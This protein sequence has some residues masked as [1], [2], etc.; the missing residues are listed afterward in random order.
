MSTFDPNLKRKLVSLKEV[1]D[2]LVFS[3]V[4]FVLFAFVGYVMAEV[5]PT[6][7][8]EYINDFAGMVRLVAEL[9][10]IGILIFIFLNN[11]FVALVSSL[12]GLF[13]GI[14]PFFTVVVNG[15]VLGIVFH[16][17]VTIESARF[18]FWGVFPHGMIEVPVILLSTAIG[19]WLGGSFFRF[20][21]M[22][23][24]SKHSLVNKIKRAFYT[25]VMIVIP[26]LF[27]SALIEVFITPLLLDLFFETGSL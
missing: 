2:T 1:K 5:Y 10:P 24:E 6:T 22:R 16:L 15:F 25:Y 8:G 20:L 27:L 23:T 13:F 19:M 4:F 7:T 12:G 11:S 9:S 3:F 26:L 14:F 21:F 18:F 17:T